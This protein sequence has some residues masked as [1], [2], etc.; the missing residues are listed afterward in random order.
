MGIPGETEPKHERYGYQ[1]GGGFKWE[2][3]PWQKLTNKWVG[4]GM[5]NTKASDSDLTTIIAKYPKFKW[6]L[7][8]T[9][10]R[11]LAHLFRLLPNWSKNA[12]ATEALVELGE[13]NVAMDMRMPRLREP[14]AVMDFVRNNPNSGLNEFFGTRK[15]GCSVQDYEEWR[16]YVAGS[17]YGIRLT[18]REYMYCE[19]RDVSISEYADYRRMA[20]NAGHDFTE[21][22]WLYPKDFK[23]LH[24][25]VMRECE[26]IRKAKEAA[27]AEAKRKKR[28]KDEK[29]YSKVAKEYAKMVMYRDGLKFF[30]PQ[31]IQDY[32]DQAK[33]L[34]QC[35]VACEYTKKMVE[36]KGKYVMVFVTKH[37]KPYA[38]AELLRYSGKGF[39]I[40][41]FNRNQKEAK[42]H[43]DEHEVALLKSWCRK[44]GLPLKES[45]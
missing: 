31:K 44:F 10:Y 9:K 41:Q 2:T 28:A 32:I 40:G 22:Y 7:A 34:H 16:R 23:T 18:F 39:K 37:G 45:A 27:E 43:A 4:L 29:R 6:L 11:T 25:R 15:Y 38:T 14:K 36:K 12:L 20:A 8:K 13:F 21:D 35:L 26:A 42:F 19:E 3:E 33:A 24:D 17:R 30:V 5:G 1:C